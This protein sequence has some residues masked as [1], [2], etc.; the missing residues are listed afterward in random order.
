MSQS[1]L[2]TIFEVLGNRTRREILTNLSS[3]PM[4]FN[5]LSKKI[6]IGQQA[7]LRHMKTLEDAGFVHAYDEKSDLGAPDRKFY[8]LDSSFF[9]SIL[10]TKD[11]FVIKYDTLESKKNKDATKL[12]NKMST[13]GESGN[14]L[15]FIYEN[16]TNTDQE[17]L[18]IET[19]LQHL[20]EIR[21][22]LLHKI[23]EIGKSNFNRIERKVLYDLITEGSVSVSSISNRVNENN[24]DVRTALD[25][26]NVQLI[27]GTVSKKA[28]KLLV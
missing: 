13:I 19:K 16:L 23:N 6:G 2:D 1:N 8:C 10:S 26:I 7:I 14:V 15:D 21:Q 17:I 28:G 22:V 20:R 3:E 24:S 12:Q 18:E 11:E 5:Q 27:N 9:L 25:Q 4:Y